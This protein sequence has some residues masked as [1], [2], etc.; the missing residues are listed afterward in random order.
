TSYNSQV[1]IA[2]KSSKKLSFDTYRHIGITVSLNCFSA[3]SRFKSK[4]AH[5]YVFEESS[6]RLQFY[7]DQRE[8]LQRDSQPLGCINIKG[9]A[10]TL[11]VDEP[12]SFGILSEGKEFVLQA[13]NHE[14]MMI[15]VMALQAN[16]DAYFTKE[17][18]PEGLGATASS[19]QLA[20]QAQKRRESAPDA[21]FGY[22]RRN[23]ASFGGADRRV[24]RISILDASALMTRSAIEEEDDGWFF[25]L[26][27]GF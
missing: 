5:Y 21:S 6:C 10:I 25:S 3:F 24:S 14:S 18:R 15:W 11:R 2:Y 13:E 27:C 20:L 7:R 22:G 16:R 19:K 23:F 8:A 26:F 17:M 1:T 12:N 4:R 9:A